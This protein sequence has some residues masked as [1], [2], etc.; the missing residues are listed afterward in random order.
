MKM[1]LWMIALLVTQTLLT[2]TFAAGGSDYSLSLKNKRIKKAFSLVSGYVRR[3]IDSDTIHPFPTEIRSII[4]R[5][6]EPAGLDIIFKNKLEDPGSKKLLA[7]VNQHL[8]LDAFRIDL[9]GVPGLGEGIFS[10][11]SMS[12]EQ[13][14]EFSVDVSPE[15]SYPVF[16]F[17][18]F[19][20]E[21]NIGS[22]RKL[23]EGLQG[24]RCLYLELKLKETIQDEAVKRF[25]GNIMGNPVADV[26]TRRGYD[27]LVYYQDTDS[28]S[29]T[30]ELMNGLFPNSETQVYMSLCAC[31]ILEQ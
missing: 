7:S 9:V 19:T 31:L 10:S 13:P 15:T 22:I 20:P 4:A 17:T 24:K 21:L 6:I 11:Y 23:T 2:F 16:R 26:G 14:P 3:T 28:V 18:N 29:L 5:Y 30:C 8:E 12:R 25:F 1:Q 27:V